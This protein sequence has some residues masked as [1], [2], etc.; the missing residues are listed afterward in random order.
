MSPLRLA[1]VTAECLVVCTA[2]YVVCMARTFEGVRFHDAQREWGAVVELR[3]YE[4]KGDR[5]EVVDADLYGPFDVWDGEWWRIPINSF[6][7]AN[8]LHLLMNCQAGW[9]LGKKLER[10]WGSWRY[11]LFMIPA[12]LCPILAEFFMG[13]TAIGFSGAICAIFGA[14]IAI[15]QF[16]DDSI[17]P[18][19]TVQFGLAFLVLGIWASE[20]EIA[21]IANL[22]HFVGLGYGWLAAWVMS[23]PLRSACVLRSLFLLAHLGVVP[24]LIYCV[25]PI[26][27]GRYHWYMADHHWNPMVRTKVQ[28]FALKCDPSLVG[29]WL[30][31]ADGKLAE[32]DER[33]AWQ[34]L[35]EGLSQNPSRRELLEALRRVW[36]RIPPGVDRMEAEYELKRVFGVQTDAWLVQIKQT[37]LASATPA[38]EETLEATTPDLDPRQFPLDQ[39]IDL[40]WQPV[41]P[42]TNSPAPI[43][44]RAPGS[45]EEG[46]VL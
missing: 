35:V 4:I 25:Q 31:L 36:R 12:C 13:A 17:L 21:K 45:A 44:P 15:K 24:L 19:L 8:L 33:A 32:G 40:D 27:N 18:D 7:H 41:V 9:I 26:G 28:G 14:L 6:H 10:R 43:D 37:V 46:E 11:A 20:L 38:I 34:L 16:D 22:A 23:G 30:R 3:L 2:L 1:P 39:R 29:L 42:K 5:R